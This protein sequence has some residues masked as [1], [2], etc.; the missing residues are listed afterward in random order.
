MSNVP[1]DTT[2]YANN[3]IEASHRR[4]RIRERTM[5]GFRS[6]GNVQRFLSV[7]GVVSN[8][9][10]RAR[11]RLTADQYRFYRDRRLMHGRWL[12]TPENRL[13]PSRFRRLL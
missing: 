11:H 6:V 10:N 2:Q 4:P 13:S 12:V 9:V 7:L 1:H 5:L 3:R 8:L